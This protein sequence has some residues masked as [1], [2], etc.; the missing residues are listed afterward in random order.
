MICEEAKD[1]QFIEDIIDIKDNDG[2]TPLYLLAEHGFRKAYDYDEDEEAKREGQFKTVIEE[3][4]IDKDNAKLDDKA[5]K[6]AN[7]KKPKKTEK[8]QHQNL[9]DLIHNKF[10]IT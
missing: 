1:L 8:K 7:L 6:N 3:I 2:L 10:N 5:D 9:V 4:C